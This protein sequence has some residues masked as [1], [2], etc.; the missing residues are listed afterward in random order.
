MDIDPVL[1]EKVKNENIEFK[2]LYEEHTRLK[3]KVEELNKL[4]FLAP[5][6]ELEKKTIQKQKLKTKDRLVK[7]LEEYEANLH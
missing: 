6:Q 4:K 3:L 2:E 7:I 1:L 5:D